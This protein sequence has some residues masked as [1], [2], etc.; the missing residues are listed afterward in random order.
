MTIEELI[1][2]LS[3]EEKV[4]L[5]K[6][7][8]NIIIATEN[9]ENTEALLKTIANY[10]IR[11]ERAIDFRIFSMDAKLIEAYLAQLKDCGELEFVLE[12]PERLRHQIDII[13]KR[14][15]MCQEVGKGY[16][17][18]EGEYCTFIYDTTEWEEVSKG[19][20]LDDEYA[21][22]NN[23]F[24]KEENDINSIIKRDEPDFTEEQ[25]IRYSNLT[26]VLS[27]SLETIYGFSDIGDF[28]ESVLRKLIAYTDYSDLDVLL[29]TVTVSKNLK[30]NEIDSLLVIMQQFLQ[31]KEDNREGSRLS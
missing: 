22:L 26:G 4:Y 23:T 3:K 15:K 6:Y 13:I 7:Y 2:S 1:S 17:N 27:S 16:K 9:A 29:A 10:G 21:T 12:R 20:N 31:E 11:I 28:G 30:S 19:I 8:G 18:D 14:I 24:Q 5:P 25:F